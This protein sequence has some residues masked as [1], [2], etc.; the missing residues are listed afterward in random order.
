M[1][2]CNGESLPQYSHQVQF[3][4]DYNGGHVRIRQHFEPNTSRAGRRILE[5]LYGNWAGRLHLLH[6]QL[7]PHEHLLHLASVVLV[8]E[9]SNQECRD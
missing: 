1:H 5:Y 7:H 3:H 4:H 2:H 8:Q 6:I 9:I